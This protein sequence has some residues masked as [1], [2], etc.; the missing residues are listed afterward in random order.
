MKPREVFLTYILSLTSTRKII[1]KMKTSVL[2][3]FL[4]HTE[5]QMLHRQ[6]K[7]MHSFGQLI[8]SHKKYFVVVTDNNTIL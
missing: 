6:K 5:T 4:V 8:Y 3:R 2:K 1:L 7:I